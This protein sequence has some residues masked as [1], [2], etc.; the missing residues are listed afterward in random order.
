MNRSKLDGPGRGSRGFNRRQFL[1]TTVAGG[2]LLASPMIAR[3]DA[4][5][6]LIAEP[7]HGV[8]YL[9]LYVGMA[10]NLFEDVAVSLVTKPRPEHELVGLVYS[11]TPKPVETHLSWYQKPATLALAVLAILV[12]LN[13]VFA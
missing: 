12:I 11:L 2:A 5:S 8:G 1:K 3:A 9:P 6:V 7:V 4:K 13:L 10:K